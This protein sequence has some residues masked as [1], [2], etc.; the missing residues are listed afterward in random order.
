MADDREAAAAPAACILKQ[1]G[2]VHMKQAFSDTEQRQLFKMI[3]GEIKT[4]PKTNPI[5]SNFHL[6]SG[7]VGAK[8]RN[9][10]L[11]ECGELL[12]NRVAAEVAKQLSPEELS[13]EPAL[14]RIARVHNGEQPVR[15]DHVSGVA[16]VAH[17]VLDNHQD[18]PMPLYT[19]SVALGDA[20]DFVV[21]KKRK[22]PARPVRACMRASLV[23]ACLPRV[24]SPGRACAHAAP[25]V[26]A[27]R[28]L[29]QPQGARPSRIYERASPSRSEWSRA[30]PSFSTAEAC[31]TGCRK[32][33]RT[34]RRPSFA[35]CSRRASKAP[36]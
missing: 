34:A 25:R 13:L 23:H 28:R 18:G 1:F 35:S 26:I 33:T 14:A 11:H 21:G 7:D 12:Y 22:P 15:V 17:S 30:T 24:I 4:R 2:V 29:R 10:P 3:S 19:M 5:P 6:S 8:Q 31:R 20:C 16:Y 9:Q 32:S 36:G 27:S